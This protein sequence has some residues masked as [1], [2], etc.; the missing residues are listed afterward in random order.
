MR[1]VVFKRDCGR[2]NNYP[3]TLHDRVERAIIRLA[4]LEPVDPEVEATLEASLDT[5]LAAL[6][7]QTAGGA[8]GMTDHFFMDG[9]SPK[10][11]GRRAEIEVDLRRTADPDERDALDGSGPSHPGQTS[12]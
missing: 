10:P 9:Y 1:R 5:L 7:R 4:V 11:I 6:D 3:R 12:S 8:G 2:G